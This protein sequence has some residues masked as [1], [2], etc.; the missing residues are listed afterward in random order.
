MDDMDAEALASRLEHHP[1]F[2][3]LRRLDTSRS[4]PALAGSD[5]SRG[6]ILDTETTGMDPAADKLIELGLLAFEYSRESCQIGRVLGS[7]SGLEDPG[8]PIPPE[9]TAIH[10]ITDE[11]VRGLR[12]DEPAIER[13]LGG[14]GVV[15]AHNAGFDRP[16]VE[17]RL[18]VFRGLP[19]ACSLREVPWDAAGIGSAAQTCTVGWLLMISSI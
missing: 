9:S 5:I 1:D 10:H 18:P 12:L 4:P 13:L 19:W 7:Y 17:A 8:R 6:V 11:M 2:R 3:V 16:F 15:I 14:A